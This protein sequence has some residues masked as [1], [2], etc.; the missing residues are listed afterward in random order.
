MN[1]ASEL[2][3]SVFGEAGRHS[4]IAIGAAELPLGA[5]IEIDVILEV[6]ES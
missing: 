2:A 6:T 3:V 4:R 5:P 1:E